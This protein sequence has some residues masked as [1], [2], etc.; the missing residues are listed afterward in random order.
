M[1]KYFTEKQLAKVV[2]NLSKSVS[3][4]AIDCHVNLQYIAT[5]IARESYHH[6]TFYIAIATP[7]GAVI[8]NAE[9]L[10]WSKCIVLEVIIY[11]NRFYVNFL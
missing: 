1:K 9:K 7:S 6:S 10:N 8:A 4:F 3:A 2:Y 11:D 5:E